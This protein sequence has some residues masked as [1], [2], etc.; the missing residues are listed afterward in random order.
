[1]TKENK[2]AKPTFDEVINE[3][4]NKGKG[5]K[6]FKKEI[7][8]ED[9]EEKFKKIKKNIKDPGM[10][11]EIFSALNSDKY[12]IFEYLIKPIIF[13]RFFKNYYFKFKE[14]GFLEYIDK[15]LKEE[16]FEEVKSENFQYFEQ[17][18]K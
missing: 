12:L 4:K 8:R 7:K 5:P 18:F 6:F 1:M 9:L 17:G 11:K 13:E 10:V 2:K 16:K 3:E 15:F 14:L